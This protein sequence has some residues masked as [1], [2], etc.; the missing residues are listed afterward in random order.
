VQALQC[1]NFLVNR[2]PA[3]AQQGGLVGTKVRV[4]GRLGAEAQRCTKQLGLQ[5]AGGGAEGAKAGTGFAVCG[6]G[7]GALQAGQQLAALHQIAFVHQQFFQ[8]AAVR[9]LNDLGA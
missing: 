9:R 5:S 6:F 1:R 4:V 7:F 8:H 3:L 2:N